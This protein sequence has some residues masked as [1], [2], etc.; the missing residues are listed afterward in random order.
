[1]T[2]RLATLD[3]SVIADLELPV[4]VSIKRSLRGPL[5]TV[6]GIALG[7][8]VPQVAVIAASDGPDGSGK[9]LLA[10]LALVSSCLVG[11]SAALGLRTHL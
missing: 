5:L 1:M 9:A 2:V 10:I 7:L 3:D 4:A 8:F 6:G 11:L